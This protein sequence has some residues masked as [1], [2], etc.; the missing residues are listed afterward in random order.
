MTLLA[1]ASSHIFQLTR[2]P[3]LRQA[4]RAFLNLFRGTSYVGNRACQHRKYGRLRSLSPVLSVCRFLPRPGPNGL[5]QCRQTL[6][7]NP[8]NPLSPAAKFFRGFCLWRLGAKEDCLAA[9]RNEAISWLRDSVKYGSEPGSVAE[10]AP[11]ALLH[12]LQVFRPLRG[13]GRELVHRVRLLSDGAG[14][15]GLPLPVVA[16]AVDK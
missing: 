4:G 3:L 10:P 13:R 7:F 8:D 11:D 9:G 1:P 16:V 14:L 15:A 12:L 5:P 6:R 2:Q